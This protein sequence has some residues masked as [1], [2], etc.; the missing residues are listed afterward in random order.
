MSILEK[1][2]Q[3]LQFLLLALFFFSLNYVLRSPYI[4][5]LYFLNE[6]TGLARG[7]IGR[8]S[9]DFWGWTLFYLRNSYGPR[10]I[11]PLQ[12]IGFYFEQGVFK[13]SPPGSIAVGLVFLSISLSCIVYAVKPY[14]GFL[15]GVVGS[16]L[17]SVSVVTAEPLL[18][19]SDRHDI[20]LLFFFS[21]GLLI[22]SRWLFTAERWRSWRFALGLFVLSIVVW[23]GFY[24]NEKATAVPVIFS[25]FALV[26][27]ALTGGWREKQTVIKTSLI[28]LMMFVLFVWYL[29]FRYSVLGTIIGGPSAYKD[30]LLPETGISL[31]LAK[32]YIINIV[33]LPLRNATESLHE[34]AYRIIPITLAFCIGTT[35]ATLDYRGLLTRRS[36]IIAGIIL[37]ILAGTVVASTVPTFR[38]FQTTVFYGHFNIRMIWLPHIVISIIIGGFYGLTFKIVR[39]L[40]LR[41]V[42]VVIV[43][44]H[45]G[46]TAIGGR[47]SAKN[48]A[49]ASEYTQRV[50]QLYQENCACATGDGS[51][52]EGLLPTK[53]W[54]NTFSSPIWL[55]ADAFWNGM[56]SCKADAPQCQMLFYYD[57][58]QGYN[59]LPLHA[60]NPEADVLD[61][62]PALLSQIEIPEADSRPVY[63]VNSHMSSFSASPAPDSSITGRIEG[64]AYEK[65][66]L[67]PVERIG[68]L[69]DGNP[70]ME[71]APN[72]SRKGIPPENQEWGYYGFVALLNIPNISL[73]EA[74]TIEV[75]TFKIENGTYYFHTLAV[76][77][78]GNAD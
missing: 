19:L 61:Y 29:W 28:I 36:I 77:S 60:T 63:A 6:D 66:T 73:H 76:E 5:R 12:L 43:L 35:L 52:V 40:W 8:F 34:I 9:D 47:I 44:G 59:A 18:W 51:Q 58:L 25:G 11:R 13:L 42:I 49:D 16:L 24:S 62:Q 3:V 23:G 65:V 75:V 22:C 14:V 71:F 69:I 2:A 72:L 31:N 54:V 55:D 17:L 46:L 20:Y 32:L 37:L 39:S 68:I 50:T 10:V 41:S 33:K 56:P 4:N 27:L 74:H 38:S 15:G 7:A 57:H 21:A 53:S 30:R 45:I 67:L 70:V 1:R 78:V 26:H 64:W 48:F